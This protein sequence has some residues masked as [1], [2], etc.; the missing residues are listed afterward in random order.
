MGIGFV[1]FRQLQE[2]GVFS[3][4][5]YFRS[6][7]HSHDMREKGKW[8]QKKFQ[9]RFSEELPWRV[10]QQFTSERL[11]TVPE[12]YPVIHLGGLSNRFYRNSVLCFQEQKPFV[13][14]MVFSHI[15]LRHA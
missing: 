10:V 8:L 11:M 4:S 1:E 7:S 6:K 14:K 13:L 15:W 2:V 12:N 5:I 9:G 3:Y